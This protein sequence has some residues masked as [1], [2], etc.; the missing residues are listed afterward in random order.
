MLPPMQNSSKGFEQNQ[1]RSL[2]SPQKD[3]GIKS[4][5]SSNPYGLASTAGGSRP[6]LIPH[7]KASGAANVSTVSQYENAVPVPGVKQAC[8]SCGRAFN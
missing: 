7:G 1:A 6:P 3:D 5:T 4:P 8:V 2:L